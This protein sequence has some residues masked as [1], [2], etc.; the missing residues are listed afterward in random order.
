MLG[1]PDVK[2]AYSVALISDIEY[3]ERKWLGITALK[4][5]FD[6]PI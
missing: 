3:R 5:I 1:Y 6:K 4:E 2:V